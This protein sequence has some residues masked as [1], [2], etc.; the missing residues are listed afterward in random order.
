MVS[1]LDWIWLLQLIN[2]KSEVKGEQYLKIIP[3][4]QKNIEKYA[5]V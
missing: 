2:I 4:A 3:L 5:E 1:G